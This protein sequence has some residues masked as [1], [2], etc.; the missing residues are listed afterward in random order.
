MKRL[1][2]AAVV[3]ALL[4][5]GKGNLNPT[6]VATPTATATNAPTATPTVRPR[7]NG[8]PVLGIKTIPS[9]MTG[10]APFTVEVNMCRCSDPDADPLFFEW[11]WGDG[12][13]S[14]HEFCRQDHTYATPG[15]YATFFCVSD[16]INESV[17]KNY[18]VTVN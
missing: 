8:P 4:A 9:P 14:F 10:T 18:T 15:V 11:S 17:C 16:H 3:F 2:P 7:P 1:L 5:C 6:T 13:H 12:N